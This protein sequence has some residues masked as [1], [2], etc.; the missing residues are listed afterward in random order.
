M[1]DPPAG[2]F[3]P[4][5]KAT[6]G[7]APRRTLLAALDAFDRE[8]GAPGLAVDLG[9]GT[10]RDAVELLRRGWR[11]FAVDAEAEALAG[12][13]ARPETQAAGGRI[14][15]RLARFESLALPAADLVNSS[16]ALFMCPADA[17]PALWRRIRE[18]LAPGGR[19]AGQL[20]GPNDSW[21]A[22]RPATTTL[23]RPSLD[24][25]LEG[26]VVEKLE[27]EETD[28]V[29]PRGEAKHWHLFHIVAR[30]A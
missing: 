15:A 25:M 21:A 3:S 4:Y 13:A 30:R 16:F 1:T 29:T 12:L 26:L 11:V 28:A 17:F 23:S 27:E 14:E 18:A 6:R 20:L 7:G 24:A 2:Y 19:F 5:Y 10:G 8:R 22:R 9:C